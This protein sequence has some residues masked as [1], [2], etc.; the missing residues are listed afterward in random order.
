MRRIGRR[1]GRR[2]G[3]GRASAIG[4]YAMISALALAAAA[5][6][7]MAQ[8]AGPAVPATVERAAEPLAAPAE[9]VA[10]PPAASTEARPAEPT[11]AAPP[12]AVEPPSQ[13]V[14]AG[15]APVRPGQTRYSKRQKGIGGGAGPAETTKSGETADVLCRAGCDAMPGAVF[16]QAP[17]AAAAESSGDDDDDKPIVQGQA[18]DAIA[19]VTCVAGCFDTASS[20]VG[21][22]NGTEGSYALTKSK[23]PAGKPTSGEWMVRINR[24]RGAEPGK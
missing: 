12:Q 15:G 20:F 17:R 1:I 4:L 11:A 22:P 14:R 19:M 10:A 2:A 5:P 7:A 6:M 3:L 18:K 9:T 21:V 13:G 24:E 8:V 23:M 16:T